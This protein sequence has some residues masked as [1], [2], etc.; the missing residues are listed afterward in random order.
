MTDT[1]YGAAAPQSA[2]RR[3]ATDL[4][5]AVWRWHFYAGLL[6]LPFMITLAI[7]G[8][9]YLFRDQVDNLVHADFKLVTPVAEQ[10][11]SPSQIIDAALSAQPGTAVK[12][13][14]PVTDRAS[15][16]ITVQPETG[17]RMAVYV[18]QYTGDVLEVRPD[19]STFAWTVRYLHSFR[20]FGPT[21]RKVI[22]I[23]GGFSILLVLT[24]V[25]LWWP[26]GQGGGVVTLRGTPARRV[27]W[28][29]THAVT[30]I[31]TGAFI[32]F[33]AVTG[34]PWSSVWGKQVNEWANGNNFGY[35][36]GVRVEVPMSGQ[37]LTDVAK[38]AW[39]LEQAQIPE[40]AAPMPGQTEIG[41]DAAV[42]IFDDLNLH[43]GY[44]VALPTTPTGVYS[45]SVYPADLGQQR[46]VHLDQYDGRPL[47]D[48]SYADYG[49]LGRWLEFGINTHMG[50]TYGLAN[51]IVL[52]LVC[53]GIV[54]LAVSAAVMWWKR[55]PAGSLG[56]PPLPSDRRVFTGLFI[57]LGIGGALFPLTGLTLLAMIGLDLLAQR[58][59]RR[60]RPGAA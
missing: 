42:R 40:T 25:Y 47:L 39:S 19:R 53:A 5:R 58:F 15:T 34:M 45:G 18:N 2:V 29:D 16:E 30:G 27:F 55:R 32:V 4:Y 17:G 21:P 43:R 57:L 46:V 35:P 22:E 8:A 1:S 10:R 38:T 12:Y 24:G 31:F 50:Q 51:Q 52:L 54:L 41:L 26:R 3:Q 48:M 44:T 33:L 7:T 14:D 60:Q 23:A 56:V 9:I 49:P 37:K 36:A 6:V 11:L 20:Y 28:R 13:T 59:L